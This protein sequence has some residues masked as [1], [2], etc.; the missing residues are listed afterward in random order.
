[1]DGFLVLLF[2]KNVKWENF[3]KEV[4]AKWKKIYFSF[5]LFIKQESSHREDCYCYSGKKQGKSQ[6]F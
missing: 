3:V 6:K 1:M 2:Y 5:L 4:I